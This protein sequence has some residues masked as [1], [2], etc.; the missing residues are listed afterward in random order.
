[1]RRFAIAV[2]LVLAAVAAVWYLRGGKG[3]REGKA[4]SGTGTAAV[5]EPATNA[6]AGGGSTAAAAGSGKRKLITRFASAE[7]RKRFA[8]QIAAA[9]AKRAAKIEVPDDAGP[10]DA[11]MR[12]IKVEQVGANLKDALEEAIPILAECYPPGPAGRTAAVQ[13]SLVGDP[14]IGTLIDA[15]QMLDHDGKPLDPKLDDCLRTTLESMALPPLAD[16]DQLKIQYSFL[17]D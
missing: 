2:V 14:D 3:D 17:F 16:G 9:R 11:G 12:Q 5:A 15:D 8:D 1:M 7:E 10:V 13:M 6:A 4:G